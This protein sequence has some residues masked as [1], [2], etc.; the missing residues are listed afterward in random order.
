MSDEKEFRKELEEVKLHNVELK[1][2]L[3]KMENKR[4]LMKKESNNNRY[5]TDQMKIETCLKEKNIMKNKLDKARLEIHALRQYREQ[6]VKCKKKE[7]TRSYTK[8]GMKLWDEI[9]VK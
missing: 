5:A 7:G 3:Q 8:K 6:V 2:K 1:D 9:Q 4:E